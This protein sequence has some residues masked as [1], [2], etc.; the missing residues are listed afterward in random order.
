V[1]PLIITARCRYQET[2]IE[3]R[4]HCTAFLATNYSSKSKDRRTMNTPHLWY[5]WSA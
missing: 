4:I 2:E 3:K 1:L 5:D